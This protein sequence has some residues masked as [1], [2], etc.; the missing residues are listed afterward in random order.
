MKFLNNV[1]KINEN[2]IQFIDGSKNK[3]PLAMTVANFETK[4][5]GVCIDFSKEK[6][7][8]YTFVLKLIPRRLKTIRTILRFWDFILELETVLKYLDYFLITSFCGRH[9]SWPLFQRPNH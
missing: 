8:A 2:L 9:A 1:V 3:G 4:K 5:Y 6:V 7:C